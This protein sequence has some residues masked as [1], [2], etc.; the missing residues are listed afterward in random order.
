MIMD[1][2]VTHHAIEQIEQLA[3]GSV[4]P[5]SLHAVVNIGIADA[6]DDAPQDVAAL[7]AA[8]GATVLVSAVIRAGLTAA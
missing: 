5:R 8:T 1:K 6:L 3:G 7:A 4:L 2:V